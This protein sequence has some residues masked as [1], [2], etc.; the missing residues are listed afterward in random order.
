MGW[1]DGNSLCYSGGK[2]KQN[3]RCPGGQ[4]RISDYIMDSMKLLHYNF[5][6]ILEVNV[7]VY[8][9]HATTMMA[10][11]EGYEVLESLPVHLKY[12]LLLGCVLPR[13]TFT[14]LYPWQTD[15][16]LDLCLLLLTLRWHCRL[17][18]A[19][20]IDWVINIRTYHIPPRI[21]SIKQP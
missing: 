2:L 1:T 20:R 4:H 21:I 17:F 8:I 9:H 5:T 18:C 13:H 14:S 10:P 6:T 7:F 16:S 11:R 3:V 19:F 12:R 15:G